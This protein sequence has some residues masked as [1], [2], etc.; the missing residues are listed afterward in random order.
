[1][2]LMLFLRVGPD[3]GALGPDF[4]ARVGIGDGVVQI[5]AFFGCF[6]AGI[7]AIT[8]LPFFIFIFVLAVFFFPTRQQVALPTGRS[9]IN[10]HKIVHWGNCFVIVGYGVFL[11]PDDRAYKVASFKNLIHQQPQ[12]RHLVVVDGHKDRPIL[13]QELLQQHQP[14]IH[15]AQPAVVA[16]E[17]L[18]FLA[19]H[20]AQPFA[21]FG[22]VDVVV[23]HPAFVAGVVRGVDVDALHL[24]GVA[25]Q[26][27]L[28]GMKVVALH[29]EVAA[30]TPFPI[31]AGKRRHRLEQAEGHFLVVFDDG[32]LADPVERGHCGDPLITGRAAAGAAPGFDAGIPGRG[33]ALLARAGNEVGNVSG[34]RARRGAG[35]ADWGGR[36]SI[37]HGFLTN[38]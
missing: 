18:A 32:V 30:V 5:G 34:A 21:D 10:Q 25:R 24:P 28:E 35:P 33:G 19:H 2:A 17:G 29:D 16:V 37:Q 26:Q 12:R 13:P 6:G 4:F 1:M 23:V 36:I 14:R 8:K 15:H 7:V 27:G 31:A 22:A 3:A 9:L 20:L 11:L 38:P